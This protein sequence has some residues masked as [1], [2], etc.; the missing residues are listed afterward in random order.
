M[1]C[2]EAYE[3]REAL[4]RALAEGEDRHA[5][6]ERFNVSQRQIRHVAWLY[7]MNRPR[8]RPRAAWK[9]DHG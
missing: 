4:A 8:G 6:A 2:Q 3:R 1:T 7:G 5:V 9:R